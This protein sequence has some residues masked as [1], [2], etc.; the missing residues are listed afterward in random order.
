MQLVS[1][2]LNSTQMLL[3][4]LWR[5]FLHVFSWPFTRKTLQY[6]FSINWI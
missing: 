1:K 3:R 4:L 5:S 6:L 2:G